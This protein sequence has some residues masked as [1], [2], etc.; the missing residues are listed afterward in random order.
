MI[1][2]IQWLGYGSFFIQGPPLIYINPSRVTRHTFLA[3]VILVG[4]HHDDH[5]SMADIRKLRGPQTRV[6]TNEHLAKEIEG[7]HI[8]RPWQ[9]I[10]VD[11]AGIKAIPAYSPNGWQQAIRHFTRVFRV[12]GQ[13]TVQKSVLQNGAAND[14]S[15]HTRSR[16]QRPPGT[17]RDRAAEGAAG[18]SQIARM[19]NELIRTAGNQVVATFCLNPDYR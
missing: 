16:Q 18:G 3:D 9:S 7:S 8:I 19:A 13:F 11:R 10:M 1:E 17:E 4:H 2:Q 14:E 6:L 15:H 12:A 5:F